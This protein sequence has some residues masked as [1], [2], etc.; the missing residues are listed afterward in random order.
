MLIPFTQLLRPD[1][2]KQS[3]TVACSHNPELC[4]KATEIL[5][6]GFVF[7][8]ELLTTGQV[9]L[10]IATQEEDVAIEICSNNEQVYVALNKLISNFNL[11]TK[12]DQ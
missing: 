5:A 10:T 12:H 8:C 7:E 1:G 4:K 9:S 6:R 11:E 3:V 2:R